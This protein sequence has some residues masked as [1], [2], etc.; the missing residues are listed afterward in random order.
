MSLHV[1]S[2]AMVDEVIKEHL[3]KHYGRILRSITRLLS[4][5]LKEGT[6]SK[7]AN[8]NKSANGLFALFIPGY[9]VQLLF[10]ST[11]E[12]RAYLEAH[13]DLW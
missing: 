2:A 13:R 5:L 11:M 1:W 4:K 10:V 7:S 9:I 8:V 6:L 3:Q 12:P